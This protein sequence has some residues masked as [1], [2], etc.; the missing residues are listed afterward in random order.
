MGDNEFNGG[1]K[2]IDI[3][4]INTDKYDK[5]QF[6]IGGEKIK[7]INGAR[8]MLYHTTS[9]TGDG[10]YTGENQKIIIKDEEKWNK[11][12]VKIFN[13][14]YKKYKGLVRSK[15][16]RTIPREQILKEMGSESTKESPPQKTTEPEPKPEPK[17]K[18]VKPK[19]IILKK[20]KKPESKQVEPKE[21]KKSVIT[22]F[23]NESCQK[24]V[25]E[26]KDLIDTITLEDKK[27]Q[28]LL[29]CIENKNRKQI[30]ENKVDTSSL[31]PHLDDPNFSKK[32]TLKK[33]FNDLKI[34]EKKREDIENIEQV[35]TNMCN[36]NIDFELEPHQMFI[37]NFLSSETP[38]NGLLLFHGLG[39]GK[40]CSSISVC[41][42]MRT[43]YKQM[44]NKKKIIIVASPVVQENYKLQ[45]F[46]KRRLK[47]VNGIWNINSCTGNKFIKEINPMNIK[48]LP[49]N[50]VISYID[51]IIRE[52]YR[53][54]GYTQFAN[55]INNIIERAVG[56]SKN[57]DKIKKRK[58]YAIRKAFS[59]R[60]LVIDEVHNIRSTKISDNKNLRRTTQNMLDLVTYAENMKLL[61]LTATP[62][63]NSASEIIWI[64]NLLNL[65]DKRFPINQNEVFDTNLELKKNSN[66]E[67]IGE[68]L[69]IQKLTGYVSYV[70]GENPFKFPFKIMPSDY[71]NEKSL[72]LMTE[73]GWKY[74][75]KQINGADTP[76]ITIQ[77]LDLTMTK[78]SREQN[79]GYDYVV[80]K[81]KD[82]YPILNDP[83]SGIQYTVIDGLQQSLN[84][85]YPVTDEEMEKN[86]DSK[87]LYGKT[88]LGR[89]MTY[90]I[91]EKQKNFQYTQNT[92]NNYG[93]I[94]S[95]KDGDDSP[96]KKY[97]SKIYS[98]IN[99]IKKSEGIVLIYS[100]YINGGCIPI[101]LAL[102]EIG[103]RRY[104]DNQKSLFSNPPV[105]DYKIPGTDY[106]AKYVMITGDPNYSG[107]ASNKKELKACTDSDN[108]KGEKVKVIIISKAGTEGL[109]FKNIRQVHILEPWFNLNRADQTIGRA[110]RNKSHCDL[111]FKERTVQVFLYGTE[112]QDNN[113]E[114]I[115]LYVYRLAEYKSIKIG[116]VSKILKE[117]SVDCI[118]NKNQKQ[119]FKDKLNKNVKL[120]LSTKEEIDFDIG[121]KN[122]SFICDFMECDYQCNSDNS[123]NNE[124][125][126]NS[127]YSKG[128]I[129]MNIDKII[130][131]IKDLFKEHY[132]YDKNQL[133]DRIRAVKPYSTEQI[134]MAFDI[135]LEGKDHL[136]IDMINRTG[137]LINIG[138]F[139]LFQP[140][141]IEDKKLTMFERRYSNKFKRKS[142]TYNNFY[143]PKNN[144]DKYNDE[145]NH[146]NELK[147][148]YKKAIENQKP[149]G[150]S[151]EFIKHSGKVIDHLVKY[152]KMDKELL[153]EFCLEH[154]FDTKSI[155]TK[156]NI[157]NNFEINN[158]QKD[159]V[160]FIQND[161]IPKLTNIIN[162]FKIG[163][164]LSLA[165]Y[166]I[167][168]NKKDK[169][170]RP[171][172]GSIIKEY[173][174]PSDAGS[175]D[176]E[177]MKNRSNIQDDTFFE[178][179]K[180]TKTWKNYIGSSA[181][182]PIAFWSK[183]R[184]PVNI[185]GKTTVDINKINN[186]IGFMTKKTDKNR[187]IVFKTKNVKRVS[188][189][190]GQRLNKGIVCPSKG[191]KRQSRLNN[192]N[193]LLINGI[194]YQNSNTQKYIEKSVKR[195]V[196]KKNKK[197]EK[198]K[199][200]T[201][202]TKKEIFML[203][204]NNEYK[205]VTGK[206]AKKK[207]GEGIY[208]IE[209]CIELEFL[210]R[211]LDKIK[212]NNKKYFFTTLE[213]VFYGRLSKI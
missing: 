135:L 175:T 204:E 158:L 46:D 41:E 17:P 38:Y 192:I 54:M 8:A 131:R 159:D 90:D 77:H 32:I 130:K 22:K 36:P 148:E 147:N 137:K 203:M 63:F 141:N 110:V 187:T 7:M 86:I 83:K 30:I 101:A 180:T 44:G 14:L 179:D 71:N 213:D 48:D 162:K 57:Q 6:I 144:T 111:P 95:S 65:N 173:V 109:D 29:R 39:T 139:Y 152:N 129:I 9:K 125:I 154:L 23:N 163:N 193:D 114:A 94:F 146:L 67:N 31:H 134:Y 112:L 157:I 72:K 98:I 133:I 184:K 82:K 120:L 166:N 76:S 177:M 199:E 2:I 50:K 171:L 142:I 212:H 102:E 49:R 33:Q 118:I 34:E 210:L 206:S 116:K 74:P 185:E 164:F 51:K 20:K 209:L 60:L 119:M 127:S 169:N 35:S 197:E 56:N 75:E 15:K 25:Q 92:I 27:F 87:A 91:D 190:Q 170:G 70:S 145:E 205:Q 126:S 80:K 124:T 103:I 42:D 106:N 200:T 68:E 59:N 4:G 151:D 89:I 202:S 138:D 1:A 84:I 113:I 156:L 167:G 140:I 40:T 155:N 55:S 181:K 161:F 62:M 105:S 150:N 52:S 28:N 93:R 149:K 21:K 81:E 73:K 194:N 182:G 37:R 24:L 5:N 174:S 121:H 58:S 168:H 191:V 153:K 61:L 43:Y 3:D 10:S 165:D 66:N 198:N 160:N 108:V 16:I 132:V 186:F 122:Y 207:Q 201:F 53:F 123:K 69:L 99:T 13:Y 189:S 178:L 88:G 64:T 211:H 104:G 115:D 47:N 183:F 176:W 143:R 128:F 12:D 19:K 100:N 196:I 26:I 45:L 96:L 172:P 136:L 188:E 107:T 78:L 18:S 97:S 85:I 11:E 117:N 195:A 208:D 79:K